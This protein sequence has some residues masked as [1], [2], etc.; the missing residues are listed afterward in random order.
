MFL[1]GMPSTVALQLGADGKLAYDV[2]I[3]Q[4]SDKKMIYSTPEA[5]EGTDD[6]KIVVSTPSGIQVVKRVSHSLFKL[7]IMRRVS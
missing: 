1:Q 6:N 2:I 5:A 4:N 7:K 3:K